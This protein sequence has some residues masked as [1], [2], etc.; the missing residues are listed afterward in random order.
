MHALLR[1]Y[2]NVVIDKPLEDV[3]NAFYSLGD[4]SKPA[5][6]DRLR[7]GQSK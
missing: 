7:T 3:M 5:S 4:R 6:H 2:R 1:N